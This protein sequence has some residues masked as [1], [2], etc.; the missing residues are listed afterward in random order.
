VVTAKRLLALALAGG[1]VA[2]GAALWRGGSA[3]APLTP[4]GT[5]AFSSPEDS[6]VFVA[7]V[8]GSNL[9]RVTS[10]AGPQF[11][12]SFSP[13]GQQIAYRDSRR[14][15][16]QDDEIWVIDID[17]AH[18]T[19]L[20]RNSANDWSPS[21]SPDGNSIAFASTRSG[22]VN[23]W[24]MATDGSNPQRL[25]NSPSE[26]PSWS[27]DGSRI[28]FSLVSP[29]AVQIGVIGRDGGGQRTLTPS[30]ENSELPAWSPDGTRI[31]FCRGFEGHRAIWIMRS[32]GT[33]ARGLTSAGSDDVGPTWSPD[34][35][36]IAFSRRGKLMIV[37]SGG[38]DSRPVGLRGMLPTWTAGSE[39]KPG[40]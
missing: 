18:A 36:F 29:G 35:H 3:G 32:D 30:T 21:W 33:H 23:L 10:T 20:T 34:G 16:N 8:D 24:T 14:G 28:A 22:A 6:D 40:A 12:P 17:G 1:L 26:Y 31:A 27:P 4:A 9:R 38:S 11:D 39:P 37:R 25:T 19:N 15:I 5:L 7:G 13:D 2:A